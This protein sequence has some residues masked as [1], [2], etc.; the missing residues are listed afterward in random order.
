MPQPFYQWD[1]DPLPIL[2]EPEWVSKEER[3]WCRKT[4]FQEAVLSRIYMCLN[5]I[6]NLG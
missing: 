4:M 2:Q 3:E 6:K 1:R 5:A